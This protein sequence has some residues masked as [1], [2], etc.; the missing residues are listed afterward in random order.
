M[1]QPLVTVVTVTRNRADLIG[2]CIKSILTQTYVNFEHIIVDGA[3]NDNTEE[4][5]KSFND[6][7]IHYIKT[8]NSHSSQVDCYDIAFENARGKYICFLDDDDEYLPVKIEKQVEL[9]ESLPEEYGLVYCWMSYYDSKTGRFIKQHSPHVSGNV[10][11]EVVET[12][13]VSGTPT[14][15]I[16]TEAFMR[17]GGWV[18]MEETGVMSDWAFGARFC[19]HYKVD[20]I[21]ES[22]IKVYVNHGHIR[23]TDSANYYRNVIPKEIKFHTYFLDTYETI[24]NKYPGK[25]WYHYTRLIVLY[26]YQGYYR[27]AWYYYV[28]LLKVRF[29]IKSMVLPFIFIL[30]KMLRL[31]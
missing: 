8:D 22:M 15:L 6:Y 7:R 26:I 16:K 18:S 1:E 30:K 24:F 9:I 5:V 13:V 12:P 31:R 3:S 28:K 25:V 11:L 2:R 14:F 23:M 10:S 29:D 21:P 27:K 17:L 4:V 20:Y 19:Q